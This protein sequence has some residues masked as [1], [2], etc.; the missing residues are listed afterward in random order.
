M[1]M[2][3]RFIHALL[4]RFQDSKTKSE[5]RL[6]WLIARLESENNFI[7]EESGDATTW[8]KNARYSLL[9]SFLQQRRFELALRL[10][11]Q[12]QQEEMETTLSSS[13][14]VTNSSRLARIYLQVEL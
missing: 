1:P 14:I 10:C 9:S 5:D 12:I 4:P 6:N 3:I 13:Q 11:R 2:Q 8:I 7:P